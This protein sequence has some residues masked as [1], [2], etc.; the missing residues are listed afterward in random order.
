MLGHTLHLQA[1]SLI[2][3]YHAS[4]VE[5]VFIVLINVVEV[6]QSNAYSI[7]VPKSPLAYVRYFYIHTV[8][9]LLRSR[10]SRCLR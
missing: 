10:P 3:K 9:L 8:P 4:F 6:N 7:S 5:V 1:I 2:Y